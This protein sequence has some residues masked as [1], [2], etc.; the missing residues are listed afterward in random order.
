MPHSVITCATPSLLSPSPDQSHSTRHWDQTQ[1]APLLAPVTAISGHAGSRRAKTL[2]DPAKKKQ[3]FLG[4][5]EMTF[6]TF[7]IACVRHGARRVL[8]VQ[9][10]CG[11]FIAVK[12]VSLLDKGSQGVQR[13][14]QLEQEIALLSQFEHQNIVQYYG[15]AKKS[16][17]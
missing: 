5:W 13:V 9:L 2:A 6:V 10:S 4:E 8:S 11:C 12:E 15:T 3:P 16:P 17:P 14:Y 7:N 1:N